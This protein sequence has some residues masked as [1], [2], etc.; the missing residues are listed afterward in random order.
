MVK[1]SKMGSVEFRVKEVPPP[2]AK[3]QFASE[4]GGTM[5]IDKMRMVNSGGVL[6]E[7]KDFDFKGVR[8]VITSYRL[9]GMYKGEQMKEDT[10]GPA[11]NDKM[12]NVIKNTKSGNTITISNIKA[13][14]VD[15][16]NT[17]V[18]ALDP[19]VLEIK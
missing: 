13:K 9:T 2:K 15:A 19:L 8:Y 14:R 10:K 12:I 7:L 18:R 6:A 11:F 16:K 4:T 3:V 1:K 17:A 5:M